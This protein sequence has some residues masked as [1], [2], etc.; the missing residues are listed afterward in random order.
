MPSQHFRFDVRSPQEYSGEWFNFK[1]PEGNERT[2]H[3]PGA[4]HIPYELV[5]AED[6]T[7]KPLEKLRA[8]YESQGITPDKETIVYCAVGARAGHTCF[9]LKYLLGYPRVRNYYGSWNEWSLFAD[10]PIE[11]HS[12]PL[13]AKIS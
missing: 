8:V 7:F 1:P 5:L 2:G 9:V 3:I 11:K 6:G 10:A 13:S 12:A 4:I